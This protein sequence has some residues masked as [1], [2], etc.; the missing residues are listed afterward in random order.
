MVA[1]DVLRLWSGWDSSDVFR[2]TVTTSGG[3]LASLWELSGLALMRGP[4]SGLEMRWFGTLSHGD[5]GEWRHHVTV[6]LPSCS[7]I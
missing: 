7:V 1:R 6:L 5:N 4:L 2:V 3:E